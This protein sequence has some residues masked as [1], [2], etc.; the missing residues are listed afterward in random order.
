MFIF[1]YF[2]DLCI[3]FSPED[4]DLKTLNLEG[5]DL[6]GQLLLEVSVSAV[7]KYG[8]KTIDCI[9]LLNLNTLLTGF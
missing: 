1:C 5:S 9:S 6:L 8:S 4:S 7:S 3:G 2:I